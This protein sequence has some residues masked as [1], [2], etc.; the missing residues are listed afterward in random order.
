MMKWRAIILSLSLSLSLLAPFS[1]SAFVI[2]FSQEYENRLK[3][4]MQQETK[5]AEAY[6]RSQNTSLNESV[7][8]TQTDVQEKEKQALVRGRR[9]RAEGEKW[10]DIERKE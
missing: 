2:Y 6:T 9:G 7:E 10:I 8:K 4:K 5:K 3:E 1:H